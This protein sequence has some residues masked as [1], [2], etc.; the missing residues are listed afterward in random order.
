MKRNWQER[1]ARKVQARIRKETAREL[2]ARIRAARE[3]RR[4]AL[5][6]VR[7]QCR[8]ARVRLRERIKQIKLAARERLRA[9]L[10]GMRT[11]ARTRC[12]VRVDRVKRL[13]A[14][15]LQ[16]ERARLAEQQ[17]LNEEVKRVGQR[18]R[19]THAR[20]S[21]EIREESDDEVRGNLP[22]ELLHVFDRVRGS[23]HASPRMSRTERFLHWAEENP[24]EVVSIQMMHADVATERMI[25]ELQEL[26]RQKYA[27]AA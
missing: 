11:D 24:D 15:K 21:R 23:I 10:A 8:A 7:H 25:R 9:E 22:D 2:R 18:L 27:G 13:G 12:R 5:K 20:S 14:T 17:R 16:L 1:E 6:G 4:A 19:K 3:Q 26:E